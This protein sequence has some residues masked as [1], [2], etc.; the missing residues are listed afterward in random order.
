[1]TALHLLDVAEILAYVKVSMSTIKHIPQ[2]LYNH[3]DDQLKD[4][5]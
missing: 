2:L 3:K 4:G 1:M 5:Q